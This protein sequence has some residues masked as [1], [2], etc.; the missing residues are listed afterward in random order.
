MFKTKKTKNKNTW[1][2][3]EK[4]K[5]KEGK[6]ERGKIPISLFHNCEC[7]RVQSTLTD[8]CLFE[9]CLLHSLGL[10]TN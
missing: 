2:K 7:L 9:L 5:D 8:V 6:G 4:K 10:I 3:K 1:R